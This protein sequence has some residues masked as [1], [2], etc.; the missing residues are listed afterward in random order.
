MAEHKN[1]KEG[2]EFLARVGKL[3]EAEKAV[4]RLLIKHNSAL[5][6]RTI[7]DYLVFEAAVEHEDELRK[8]LSLPRKLNE[9]NIRENIRYLAQVSEGLLNTNPE[10]TEVILA[11]L[12]D[13]EV[14]ASGID[15]L[16]FHR[17][18]SILETAMKKYLKLSFFTWGRIRS[19]L[20]N[21]LELDFVEELPGKLP[22][23]EKGKVY[24]VK[25]NIFK[26]WQQRLDYLRSK[27]K[28]ESEKFWFS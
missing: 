20:D 1:A 11:L 5:G 26:L 3:Q 8:V 4:L 28:T 16:T 6:V 2:D 25:P 14:V 18:V 27:P 7:R 13:T 23:W 10:R 12:P 9:K 24:G 17:K 15:P 22:G 19:A 21:L